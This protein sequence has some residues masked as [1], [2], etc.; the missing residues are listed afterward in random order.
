MGQAKNLAKG[1]D[2]PGQPKSVTGRARTAQ[3]RDG[4]WDKK[5]SFPVLERPFLLCPVL[6]RVPSRLLAIPA[7]SAPNFGCPSL[8]RPLARFLACP[9]VPLSRDNKGASVPL[10]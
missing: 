9:I 10:S 4:T 3:I 1:W 5:N 7:H 6:S 2:R 8:S